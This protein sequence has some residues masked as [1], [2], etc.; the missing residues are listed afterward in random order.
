MALY[1]LECRG[2]GLEDEF[3]HPMGQPHPACP[4]CQ[5]KLR[6]VITVPAIHGLDSM[7]AP[8]EWSHVLADPGDQL[9]RHISN[10]GEWNRVLQEKGLRP[11]E[12]GE[13][14]QG[15]KRRREADRATRK[16]L[17][18]EA[19][20]CLRRAFDVAKHGHEAVKKELDS[21]SDDDYSVERVEIEGRVS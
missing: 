5:G 8:V 19:R 14:E 13:A 2:C 9:P 1:L 4:S 3:F 18:T 7:S 17:A 10:R 16:R 11:V 12:D 6:S 21:M 20:A 15:M